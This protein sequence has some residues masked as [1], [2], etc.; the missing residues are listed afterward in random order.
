MVCSRTVLEHLQFVEQNFP[1]EGLNK[2]WSG[3]IRVKQ[4]GSRSCQAWPRGKKN[5]FD[6]QLS[7]KFMM[8]INVKMPTIVGILT[9]ISMINTTFESFEARTIFIFQYMYIF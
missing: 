5:F 8:L 7:L 1:G 9:F 6:A 4:F 2:V 3:F